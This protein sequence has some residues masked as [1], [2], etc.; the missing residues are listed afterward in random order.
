ME[1]N[2]RELLGLSKERIE[3]IRAMRGAGSKFTMAP[4]GPPCL[5]CGDN[6]Y[7]CDCIENETPKE[8]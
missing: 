5:K 7:A 3:E 4:C 1:I 8:D 6:S 2:L